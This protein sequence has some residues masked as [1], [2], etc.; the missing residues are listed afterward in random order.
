MD[1]PQ[2]LDR[3]FTQR[4]QR[5]QETAHL[6]EQIENIQHMISKRINELD[7]N[8][9][10][11]YNDLLMRQKDLQDR[12]LQAE[13]RLSQVNSQIRAYESD[14]KS[15]S[16]RKE[17]VA[18]ERTY[19]S[20]K[21]DADSLQEELDIANMD[22]KEAHNK[23]VARVNNFKNGSKQL[24]EKTSQLRDEIAQLRRALDDLSSS[25]VSEQTTQE[26]TEKYELL[27]KVTSCFDVL[28]ILMLFGVIYCFWC[29][30]TVFGDV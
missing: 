18:L 6:E 12:L 5:E 16:L 29:Y 20:L 26:D 13:S 14:D 10:R 3:V 7:P 27:V 4:K 30:L 19:Q 23:F 28:S 11:A 24:E 8:R 22:P 2:D 1:L 17:F 15:N 25:A 21:R 9:L